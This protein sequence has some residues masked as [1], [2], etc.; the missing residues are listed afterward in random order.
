M[1]VISDEQ[2]ACQH[3]CTVHRCDGGK[4]SERYGAEV[5]GA[6]SSSHD[7][8]LCQADISYKIADAIEQAAA[9]V[10]SDI[11][12]S[13]ET[14]VYQADASQQRTFEQVV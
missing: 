8:A 1:P 11:P 12:E 9:P 6:K 14:T 4:E 10:S 5:F 13:R 2:A 3:Q 7:V